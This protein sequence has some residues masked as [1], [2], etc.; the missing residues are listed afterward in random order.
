MKTL[1]DGINKWNSPNKFTVED[2]NE[3]VKVFFGPYFRRKSL[4]TKERSLL[5]TELVNLARILPYSGYTDLLSGL[6]KMYRSVIRK[7]PNESFDYLL[8]LFNDVGD[9]DEKWMSAAITYSQDKTASL[10]ERVYQKF[11][12]FDAILEGSY[13]LQ[14]RVVYGF[15]LK[16]TGSPF[17]SNVRSLDFGALI[18]NFP[19]H[20]KADFS[21][22][23]EDP[24]HNIK[25]SQWRN[26]SA[27]KNF[28]MKSSR[29]FEI[30]YGRPLRYFKRLTMM[31]LE[32]TVNWSI[33]ALCTI[34]LCNT[35]IYIE[36]MSKLKTRGLIAPSLKFESIITGLCHNL[37]TVGFRCVCYGDSKE[38]F[39]L[40]LQDNLN[41]PVNNAIS[42]A[43]QILDQL[44]LYI[45]KSLSHRAKIKRTAIQLV[46]KDF[47]E[48]ASASVDIDDALAFV[49]RKFKMKKYV[50]KVKFTIAE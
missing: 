39:T 41:R 20:L 14:F 43:S 9:A 27:H 11:D 36:Y 2:W 13:K 40:S 48:L 35:I 38:L 5:R 8:H 26:I 50:T 37:G 47:N 7:Y 45:S 44:S 4:L 23:L 32:R 29:T 25:T 42:H 3:S 1:I 15:A 10:A 46:D 24:E 19:V 30:E 12:I 18:T 16:Y 33:L 31:S 21:T 34:R 22:L 49:N 17:P 28:T 6:L